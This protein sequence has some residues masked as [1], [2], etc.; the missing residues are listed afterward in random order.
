[1]GSAGDEALAALTRFRGRVAAVTRGRT[2]VSWHEG[3]TPNRRPAYAIDVVD[4]TGAGDVFHG[5]YAFAIG[6]G[7]AVADAMSFA[8]AAAALKCTRANGRAGIPAFDD[9][10]AFMRNHP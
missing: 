5:A 1:V 8:S 4:T 10:V 3:G 2:G 6:G 9:C 7:L